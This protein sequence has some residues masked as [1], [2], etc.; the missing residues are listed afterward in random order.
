MNQIMFYSFLLFLTILIEFFIYLLFIRKEPAKLFF[1]S[2][3]INSLTV[4]IANYV[5]IHVLREFLLIEVAVTFF[6]SVLICLLTNQKYPKSL[7]ISFTANFIT[8]LVGFI[9]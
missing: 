9:F 6:E 4:P 2:L 5:Y 8:A 1:Y 7:L 3:L